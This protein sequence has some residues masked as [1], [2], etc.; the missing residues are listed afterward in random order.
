[1]YSRTSQEVLGVKN[2]PA[3]ARDSRDR[4]LITS[5]GGSPEVEVARRS[6][7]LAWNIPW[8]EEPGR[9][10]FM[11]SQTAKHSS[12]LTIYNRAIT[13]NKRGIYLKFGKRA[14]V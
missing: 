7:I 2:L 3:N 6:S 13:L 8:T 4:G 1:M 14:D 9:L 10:Q 5:L 11:R 12:A